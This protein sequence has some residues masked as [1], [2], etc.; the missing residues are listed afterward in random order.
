MAF[1]IFEP[2][3]DGANDIFT[4][5]FRFIDRSHIQAFVDGAQ[6]TFTWQG[7]TTIRLDQVPQT[8]AELRIQRVTPKT[9]IVDFK[10]GESLSE[11]DLDLL[12]D[13]ALFLAQETEDLSGNTLVVGE[14]ANY[15]AGGR[16]IGDLADPV[17]DEDAVT[18]GWA[19]TA[20]ASELAQ[21]KAA[22]TGA[23]TAKTQSENS[24][25]ASAQ[26]ANTAVGAS[27]TSQAARDASQSA[28]SQAAASAT[29]S[30]NARAASQT[31]QTSA[32]SAR[33]TAVSNANQTSQD[34]TAVAQDRTAVSGM[35]DDAEEARNQ[36]QAA[37]VA[38]GGNIPALS[39]RGNDLLV[40]GPAKN[41]TELPALDGSALLNMGTRVVSMRNLI[42]DVARSRASTNFTTAHSFDVVPTEPGTKLYVA[43]STFGGCSSGNNG[44][45]GFGISTGYYNNS[46]GFQGHEQVTLKTDGGSAN[47]TIRTVVTRSYEVPNSALHDDDASGETRWTIQNLVRRTYNGT[48]Y[49]YRSDVL[50]IEV[51]D[52]AL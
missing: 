21:A 23:E 13:H 42:D 34:R 12:N 38:A 4:L 11:T 39:I 25:A 31:A 22:R 14:S 51:K 37:A 16:R 2:V 33:D 5:P 9:P 18:K 41:L 44:D 36:A 26:A 3:A 27:S 47:S 46:V 19:E 24:A 8:G 29:A 43:W 52:D 45:T 32:E 1:S 48:S 35:K 6:A 28:A 10:D 50:V 15:E 30:D 17:D 20:M 49:A 40:P 7:P